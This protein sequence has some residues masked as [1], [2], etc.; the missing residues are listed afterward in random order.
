M[1]PAAVVALG[2][3]S[4][5][6]S[7]DLPNFEFR[8]HHIGQNVHEAFPS[9]FSNPD[10]HGL[11]YYCA[12]NKAGFEYACGD[13]NIEKVNG[14]PQLGDVRIISVRYK[15]FEEKI[16]SVV[17]AFDADAFSD[18]VPMLSGKY[19]KPDA[20]RTEELK[21]IGG[22]TVQNFIEEW[23]FK[24]GVLRISRYGASIRYGN[25]E[26]ENAPISARISALENADYEAKGKAAF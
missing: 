9:F 19:G 18:L 15:V 13:P 5:A 26:F 2:F 7:Q 17:V 25:I 14:Y 20:I 11:D 23:K 22:G 4:P 12:T 16:F 6:L 1:V 21:T 8:G 3:C 10:E 24:E